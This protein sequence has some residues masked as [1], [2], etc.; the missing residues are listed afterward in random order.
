MT[1]PRRRDEG[2]TMK[3]NPDDGR[4]R[5]VIGGVF[6]A[7]DG[8]RF[9]VKRAAGGRLAVEADV[10]GDGHDTLRCMLRHRAENASAWTETEMQFVDNDRWRGEFEVVLLF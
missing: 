5:A 6:P 7:V 3:N 10:F 2:A 4:R 1:P 8:G 9:P